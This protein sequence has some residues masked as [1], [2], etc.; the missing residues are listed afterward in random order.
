MAL[1]LLV[2]DGRVLAAVEEGCRNRVKYTNKLPSNSI[3]C[4]LSTAGAELGEID[5]VAF[6]ATKAYCKIMLEPSFCFSTR[7]V[8]RQTVSAAA[9]GTGVRAEIDPSRLS[10]VN[11]HEAHAAS[12]VAM[13]E[14]EQ[15]LILAVD[16]GGECLSGSLSEECDAGVA[17][18][19]TSVSD[20]H[21]QPMPACEGANPSDVQE[22]VD[23]GLRAGRCNTAEER[24]EI[25]ERTRPLR[26]LLP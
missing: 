18:N 11:Q 21:D 16:G 22:A 19:L 9:V 3:R 14:F 26:M 4:C 7:Y 25:V 13:S 15:S 23:I 20:E 24:T 8:A 2:Q 10:F 5:G 6:Y 1:R 12:E 17:R